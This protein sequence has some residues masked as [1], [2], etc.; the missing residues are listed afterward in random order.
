MT[1]WLAHDHTVWAR[2][3][4]MANAYPGRIAVRNGTHAFT[5]AAL[6][7][8][9]L[10]VAAAIDRRDAA[11]IALE[12]PAGVDF[13]VAALAA[14]RQDRPYLPLDPAM[15]PSMRDAI[16]QASGVRDV[17]RALPAPASGRPVPPDRSTP[18]S[19]A[20]VL[21]T[22]GSTGQ[23][24]GVYQ[25]QR[26][27]L[28]DIRQY[29]QTIGLD[30]R[31]VMTWLYAPFTGGAIR[32]LYGALL[33]GAE[34]VV[35]DPSTLGLR[36]IS[37]T[38]AKARVTI[39]HAIPPLLRAWL[40]SS[41]EPVS[42][43][44]IRMLYVAGDRFFRRDLDAI[45]RVFPSSCRIYTG[46]GATECTTLH[47]HWILPQDVVVTT[48]LV[49]SGYDVPDKYT[50]LVDEH[51]HEVAAGQTGEI[52]VTS[53]FIAL[54]YWQQP[55]RS[56]ETF[57]VDPEDATRRIYRTGDLGYE[58]P[59]GNLVFVGRKDSVLKIRGHRVETTR[60][61]AVLRDVP[62]MLNVAVLASDEAE[63][64]LHA[65]L[66]GD[67]TLCTMTPAERTVHVRAEMA[68]HLPA[69]AIPASF[70]WRD[71]I[72]RLPSHKLDR[73]AGRPKAL[74]LD[75]PLAALWQRA[76]GSPSMPE[77]DTAFANAG[78]TSLAGMRLHAEI[79]ALAG[80]S[81]PVGLVHAGQTLRGLREQLTQQTHVAMTHPHIPVWFVIGGINWQVPHIDDF[82]RA[83]SGQFTLHPVS[84][85][86][87]AAQGVLDVPS[88]GRYVANVVKAWHES[89]GGSVRI[90]L[91]GMSL[92]ALI[93]H[94]A[95]CQ[96]QQSGLRVCG[97]I[98]YD[99][100]P[101][102]PQ[103][104]TAL[105]R[106]I[107]KAWRSWRSGERR[108][109]FAWAKGALLNNLLPARWLKSWTRRAATGA[110]TPADKPYDMMNRLI[111]RS[112]AAW[113]PRHYQD[114]LILIKPIDGFSK[115]TPD[116]PHDVGWGPYATKVV[117]RSVAG[118]HTEMFAPATRAAVAD[119]MAPGSTQS[120]T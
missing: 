99:L 107:R 97:L 82:A 118:G 45:R 34:L 70:E 59:D 5:Y 31:D 78:G 114:T 49:P 2:F 63:P 24:K 27:L 75:D 85:L 60:V 112:L 30:E 12:L 65:I 18:D 28:H 42:C 71:A 57:R 66:V 64:E 51:G 56:R 117:I 94:E 11:P 7:A 100:G 108:L 40:A 38:L 26:I 111:F 9:A 33:H 55:E 4:R 104:S 74:N 81:L 105:S 35:M 53:A 91:I 83:Y 116:A 96:L 52:E 120:T 103:I 20:C 3:E 93:A 41:P 21:T 19:I 29:G 80:E 43:Q 1:G 14:L 88:L 13:V 90:G 15:H 87:V 84:L 61:E 48:D 72:P 17:L 46:L 23:P 39:L 115:S 76:T 68:R 109:T 67:T 32:D 69:H 36:G 86:D 37:D 95:A 113:K 16:V 119:C 8:R 47:R 44:T 89:R 62:G 98:A 92:G 22:S 110:S 106:R 6:R 102:S 77:E 54:G 58:L 79:E 25:S 50:R 10:E 101:G 73:R